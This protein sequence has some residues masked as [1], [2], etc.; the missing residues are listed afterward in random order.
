MSVVS[1]EEYRK[2]GVF[3]C[4]LCG[5]PNDHPLGA[6]VR[7]EAENMNVCTKCGDDA[8]SRAEKIKALPLGEFW[9]LVVYGRNELIDV[10]RGEPVI[11]DEVAEG[12][13]DAGV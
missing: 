12:E 8:H 5:K 3:A 2:L 6:W 4:D 13:D 9:K 1:L 7:W 11:V 10:I